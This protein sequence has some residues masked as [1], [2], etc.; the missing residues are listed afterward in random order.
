MTGQRGDTH[1]VSLSGR[2]NQGTWCGLTQDGGLLCTDFE[3]FGPYSPNRFGPPEGRFLSVSAGLLHSCGVREDS[4]VACWRHLHASDLVGFRSGVPSGLFL[5]VSAGIAFTEFACGV[6]VD[7][8]IEC[9]GDS[10]FDR[11]G[12][13]DAPAGRFESVS[14]G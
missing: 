2:S 6:R 9:W 7:R 4:S 10:E 12:R 3:G 13:L 5:S 11:T 14:A 1:L 8:I